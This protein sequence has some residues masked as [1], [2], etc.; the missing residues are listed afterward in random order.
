M[1]S[2]WGDR[3]PDRGLNEQFLA[4][5]GIEEEF[6][7]G[8]PERAETRAEGA[9]VGAVESLAEAFTD[10]IV[11]AHDR[12][13][14][15]DGFEGET[16][17]EILVLDLTGEGDAPVMADDAENRIV[18]VVPPGEAQFPALLV[19][20]EDGAGGSPFQAGGEPFDGVAVLVEELACEVIHAADMLKCVFERGV[21]FTV[22]GDGIA[23][24]PDSIDHGGFPAGVDDAD[25]KGA[26]SLQGNGQGA[27]EVEDVVASLTASVN[28][29]DAL[30]VVG[31]GA[32]LVEEPG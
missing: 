21:F 14:S 19:V 32:G 4:L 11:D 18:V 16:V 7:I 24:V 10:G 9:V 30:S 3:T 1:V 31:V 22:E 17:E 13:A 12:A 2:G 28:L 27:E 6:A 20:D 29:G 8:E 23:A 25:G 15:V 5:A 26:M